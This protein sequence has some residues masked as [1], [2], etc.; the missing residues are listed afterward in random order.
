MQQ[1]ADMGT[2]T[3]EIA[4]VK[5]QL[6]DAIKITE[7]SLLALKRV[8]NSL[9]AHVS[10]DRSCL[11]FQARLMEICDTLEETYTGRTIERPC[12]AQVEIFIP[13]R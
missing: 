10:D 9:G 7:G 13:R 1:L 12:R 11:V 8:R 3:E 4:E 6:K 2:E 5:L